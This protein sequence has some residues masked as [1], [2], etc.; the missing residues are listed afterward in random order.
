[1]GGEQMNKVKFT[2]ITRTIDP[3]TRIHYLDA[4]DENGQHWTA[5]MSHQVEKWLCFTD[6]WKKDV[7]VPYD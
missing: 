7:Q 2:Y 1:M 6:V 5:E 4:I 3:K